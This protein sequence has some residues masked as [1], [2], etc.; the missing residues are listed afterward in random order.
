ME[1]DI[2]NVV[3]QRKVT[4]ITEEKKVKLNDDM[5]LKF[6]EFIKKN[7]EIYV[8]GIG[9]TE[10]NNDKTRIGK[11]LIGGM[12]I[13]NIPTAINKLSEF[14]LENFLYVVKLNPN[15]LIEEDFKTK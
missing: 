12:K 13:G 2:I 11:I 7:D 10:I 5:I 8:I 1:E 4:D 3:E 15:E 9:L 14:L 6:T